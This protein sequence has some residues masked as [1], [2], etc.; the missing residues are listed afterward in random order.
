MASVKWVMPGKKPGAALGF[1]VGVSSCREAVA[2]RVGF[3]RACR[4]GCLRLDMV[5]EGAV[6]VESPM[7]ELCA[8]KRRVRG[9][10]TGDELGESENHGDRTGKESRKRVLQQLHFKGQGL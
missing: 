2:F 3:V 9:Y 1:S 10:W 5:S 4:R 7:D 6:V 8:W